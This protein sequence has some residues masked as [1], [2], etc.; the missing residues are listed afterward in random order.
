MGRW[1]VCLKDKETGDRKT[2]LYSK[3]LMS[4]HLGRILSENEETDH[5][6]GN[7]QNDSI[8]NLQILTR[9]ENID[10]HSKTLHR[11]IVTLICHKCGKQFQR[12]KRQTYLIRGGLPRA[13]CSR[14]CNWDNNKTN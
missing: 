2:I 7:K 13:F 8:S 14:R 3:F 5:I 6:D 12:E 9:K 11:T 1:Q 4:V 10:K